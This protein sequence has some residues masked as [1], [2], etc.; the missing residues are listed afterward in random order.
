MRLRGRH[1]ADPIDAY[2]PGDVFDALLAEIVESKAQPVAYL[3]VH[4][5]RDQ[6]RSR[7]GQGFEPRRD[8]N[9]ITVEVLAVDDHVAEIDADAELDAHVG[10]FGRIALGHSAL[11]LDGAAHGIDDAGKFHQHPVA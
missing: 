3:L 1:R 9:A 10:R 2:R 6:Y 4:R 5:A 7:L 11:H 8:I